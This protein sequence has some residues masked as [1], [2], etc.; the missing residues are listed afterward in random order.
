MILLVVIAV[1]VVAGAI[2]NIAGFGAGI[3]MM[4]IFPY[5]YGIIG[6]AA[7]NQGICTGMT[8]LLAL[9]YRKW[10][11]PK[12]VALPIVCYLITSIGTLLF[13]KNIDLSVL[14]SIFG[15]FLMALSLYFL[16]FQKRVKLNPTPLAAIASGS[17]A[18]V[19]SGL[20][21]LGAPAI[22]LYMLAITD[23]RET[24]MGNLQPLFA[25]TNFA[26]LSMRVVQHYY[27]MDMLLPAVFGFVALLLGQWIG[28]RI[29]GKMSGEK[30]NQV[31]YLLVG[32]SGAITLC[33]QLF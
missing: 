5:F 28:S 16:H 15:V 2:Q 30:I 23:S 3:I 18:G 22:A 13:I 24:Y 26:G 19:L 11:D 21:S 9:K 6:A 7:M 32:I 33:K 27:T 31:I 14:S 10:L 17:I 25:I 4:L 20:F 1:S 8:I 29:A 12:V